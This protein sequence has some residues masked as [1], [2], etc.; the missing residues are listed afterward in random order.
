MLLVCVPINSSSFGL[1][2]IDMLGYSGRNKI[3]SQ[4]AQFLLNNTE[5]NMP[6]LR[7]HIIFRN[8]QIKMIIVN[9]TDFE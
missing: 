4:A 2:H 8:T 6:P 3:F 5:I 1:L 9:E 7:T